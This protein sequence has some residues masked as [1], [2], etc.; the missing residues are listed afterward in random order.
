MIVDS[1]IY[2]QAQIAD[3]VCVNN[4]SHVFG[5]LI[6]KGYTLITNKSHLFGKGIIDTRDTFDHTLYCNDK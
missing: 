1:Y 6:I 2:N 4:E 5:D 3:S